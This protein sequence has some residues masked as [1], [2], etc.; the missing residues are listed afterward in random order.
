MFEF[1]F[2]VIAIID[3]MFVGFSLKYLCE[4]ILGNKPIAR[5]LKLLVSVGAG[6][7][8]FLWVICTYE[9]TEVSMVGGLFIIFTP[10]ALFL[11]LAI[12]A[13]MFKKEDK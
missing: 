3:G 13:Y 9:S 6:I 2:L 7:G 4:L 10:I 8:Y 1:I 11:I 5:L 12:I